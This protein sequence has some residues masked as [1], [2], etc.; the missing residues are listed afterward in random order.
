M[1][2]ALP[3]VRNFFFRIGQLSTF[4]HLFN[5]IQRYQFPLAWLVWR[6]QP[7]RYFRVSKPIPPKR[8]FS[9]YPWFYV[10]KNMLTQQ[11]LLT[12]QEI[13]SFSVVTWHLTTNLKLM[14]GVNSCISQSCSWPRKVPISC[15][16]INTTSLSMILTKP[17]SKKFNKFQLKAWI[18][19]VRFPEP[20]CPS[21]LQ[22]VSICF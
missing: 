1:K 3:N 8:G 18:Q 20:H 11:K 6:D 16:R 14:T 2:I 13:L 21:W 15:N 12:Q 19:N 7:Q 9:R 5:S 4:W 10:S 22:T 17:F